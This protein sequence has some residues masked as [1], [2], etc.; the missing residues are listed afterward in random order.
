MWES[1]LQKKEKSTSVDKSEAKWE[2]IL[3]TWT[4]LTRTV[5]SDKQLHTLIGAMF[6]PQSILK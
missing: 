3:L 2:A 4:F 1:K 6:Q 5:F